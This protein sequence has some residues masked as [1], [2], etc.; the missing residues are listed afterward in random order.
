MTDIC[1]LA[2]L[3][4]H[5]ELLKVAS[6]LL[7]WSTSEESVTRFLEE[8]VPLLREM[9]AAQYVVLACAEKGKWRSI[10]ATGS[11]QSLPLELL[12]EVVQYWLDG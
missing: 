10:A 12:A 8:A 7:A 4:S 2:S 1:N 3:A 9:T 11:E 6:K 5:P